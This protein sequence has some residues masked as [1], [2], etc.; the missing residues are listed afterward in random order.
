[1]VLCFSREIVS[2]KVKKKTLPGLQFIIADQM[3]L[4]SPPSS[5]DQA[6][7]KTRTKQYKVK[8]QEPQTPLRSVKIAVSLLYDTHFATVR[9]LA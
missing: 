3:S 7:P 1:M 4:L 2:L 5:N 8:V 6:I 9:Q